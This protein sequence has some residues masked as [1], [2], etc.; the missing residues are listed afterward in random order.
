MEGLNNSLVV[1]RASRPASERLG[2]DFISHFAPMFFSHIFF[3]MK[4]KRDFIK[5]LE[6]R[7]LITYL[8]R[9]SRKFVSKYIH[10]F[11]RK[12]NFCTTIRIWLLLATKFKFKFSIILIIFLS[13]KFIKHNRYIGSERK[14]YYYC[15]VYFNRNWFESI[16]FIW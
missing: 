4:E 5:N 16:L 13:D 9:G 2:F 6:L 14:F 12:V 15:F 1:V 8:I 3:Q 7:C 10:Q 11:H